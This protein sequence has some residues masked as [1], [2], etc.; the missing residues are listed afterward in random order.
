MTAQTPPETV[1]V[2]R[3]EWER[4]ML[5]SPLPRATKTVLLVLGVFMSEDGGDARPGL[6]NFVTASGRG[7]SSLIEH[8]AVAVDAGYLD[9]VERGGFRRKT[10][11][12]SEYA[13]SVPKQV[14]ADRDGILRAPPWRRNRDDG[15]TSEKPDLRQVDEGPKNRTLVNHE[16]PD[17]RDEGP[18]FP[19]RTSEKPDPTTQFHHANNTTPPYPPT[20][21]ATPPAQ[22]GAEEGG[23]GDFSTDEEQRIKTL[24]DAMHQRRPGDP[25]WR[26]A[27]IRE[28]ITTCLDDGRA[29]DDIERAFPLCEAD[30]DTKSPGRLRLDFP[31][32]EPAAA[33]IPAELGENG[34]V[35]VAT[36]IRNAE[37]NGPHCEDHGTPG[38]KFLHP[39]HN[40][41][42]CAFCRRGALPRQVRQETMA[43]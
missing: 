19:S 2:G 31:W 39:I 10:A 8:L 14:W 37:K 35:I 3:F 38:G 43:S 20:D 16:G 1:R 40:T 12:A 33:A 11:R 32:W 27:K 28:A 18:G 25:R 4:L 24:T 7:R 29:L 5:M 17:S 34:A 13:A 26:P 22:P 9:V 21:G 41:P 30:P 23:K 36:L 6:E 15:P 42:L